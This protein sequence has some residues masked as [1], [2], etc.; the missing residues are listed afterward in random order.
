VPTTAI[1]HSRKPNAVLIK[2]PFCQIRFDIEELWISKDSQKPGTSD[3]Q[4]TKD[5][6]PRFETR[7]GIIRTTVKYDWIRAQ[8]REMPEN[9]TWANDFVERARQW[10]NSEIPAGKHFIKRDFE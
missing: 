1:V 3:M 2:T 9:E 8:S 4:M 7:T 6:R 5:N 10:F